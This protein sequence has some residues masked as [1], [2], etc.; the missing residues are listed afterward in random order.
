MSN[1]KSIGIKVS[2]LSPLDTYNYTFSNKGGNWPVKLS[3]LSGSFQPNSIDNAYEIKSYVEFCATTG[4]CPPGAANVLYNAPYV[5]NGPGASVDRTTLY[6]V[7]GLSL[8]S[9]STSTKVLD[10]QTLVECDNCLPNLSLTA[11]ETIMLDESSLNTKQIATTVNGLIPNQVYTYVFTSIDSNWP[12]KVTPVSGTIR[13][14]SDSSNI[15]SLVTL[16]A[17]SIDCANGLSFVA[18]QNCD[19]GQTPF[20]AIKLTVSPANGSLQAPVSTDFTVSCD[21][22]IPKL[23]LVLPDTVKLDRLS[24]NKTSMNLVASNLKLGKQYIY[25]INS[26]DA[27]WPAIVTPISGKLTAHYESMN[28]PLTVTLCPSTGLCPSV[29]SDVID[30]SIDSNCLLGY[31]N[32]ER[33]IRFNA[34][35]F[36]NECDNESDKVYS[37]DVTIS[38]VDCLPRA[39]VSIPNMMLLSSDSKNINTFTADLT[40]LVPG[41]KY[42]YEFKSVG[43]NWPT[44][45]YPITGI[46]STESTAASLSSRITFCRST[47]LCDNAENVLA[48]IFD[49]SS[50]Y[51]EGLERYSSVVLEIKP[52]DCSS[53]PS[54]TSNTML[55]RCDDCLP[56]ASLTHSSN[57]VVLSTPGT[58][59]YQLST[60]AQNLIPG[61]T[62]SYEINYV[63]SNWPTIVSKQSGEFVAVASSK[64]IL[65]ELQF[66]FPSG[67]CAKNPVDVMPYRVSPVTANTNKYATINL[68]ITDTTSS[69]NP[70]ISD[71]FT[72][73]CSNC[74]PN[75]NY[76]MAFSGSPTLVLP[77]NCCSGNQVMRINIGGAIPGDIHNY[78]LSSS[79][80]NVSF[81]PST[82]Q[83]IFKQG[84]SGTIITMMSTSLSNETSAITQC[85]LTN[86]S[87]DIEAVDFLVVKCGSTAC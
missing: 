56:T 1:V 78:V 40:D 31:S 22:C 49:N 21:N 20:S 59:R 32:M 76:T 36:S 73:T 45:I 30:Y 25:N 85:K 66:C 65:T 2:G 83:M 18:T 48:Y 16:C 84:G 77:T 28:I 57:S 12:V 33:Y 10:T 79:S 39:K 37:N 58:N 52:L 8:V 47:T 67:N 14:S 70:T 44:L 29:S 42:K 50:L 4:L 71:D 64:N 87:S 54:S 72:L 7:I 13:S 63:D 26:V 53:I 9:S 86:I 5:D 17:N 15:K 46:I 68:S 61:E 80:P 43:S 41:Q 3:P 62:Y 60:A 11:E 27:N 19:A 24:K 51:S 23:T 75:I 74:L 6:S 34:D 69:S 82:G 55:V 38:C 81:M 35:I